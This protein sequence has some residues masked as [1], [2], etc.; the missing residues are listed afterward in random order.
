MPKQIKE[1]IFKKSSFEIIYD[2]TIFDRQI[3]TI[4]I[5]DNKE[6]PTLD[7]YDQYIKKIMWLYILKFQSPIH[8][9]KY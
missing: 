5:I 3:R 1:L 6:Y 8:V 4:F 2:F 9:Y 7:E